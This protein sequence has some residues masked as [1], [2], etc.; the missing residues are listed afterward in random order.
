LKWLVS[1]KMD[2]RLLAIGAEDQLTMKKIISVLLA[3]LA[4]C[5]ALAHADLIGTTVAG[6]LNYAVA[7]STNFLDPAQGLV[8][9]GYGNN[10]GPNVVIGSDIEFGLIDPDNV[11]L[12]T[13][14]F[15]NSTLHITNTASQPTQE[16]SYVA[17]FTDP[18]FNSF[19]Q[20]DNTLAGLTFSFSG[21][22][23]TLNFTGF[24]A[25]LD[26][27]VGTADV[28]LFSLGATAT[29][30]PSSL[31]LLGTGLCAFATLLRR[32]IA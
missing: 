8:P 13:F 5:P 15:S 6:D 2:H 31:V 9:A 27:N 32:R 21:D 3:A 16:N 25:Q 26:G 22:V 10:F 19:R 29:P 30:E 1:E 12:Y 18:T 14:D 17:T 28:S 24:S 4:V 23:L 11:V 20:I 7:G